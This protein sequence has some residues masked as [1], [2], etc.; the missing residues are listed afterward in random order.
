[1]GETYKTLQELGVPTFHP[2]KLHWRRSYLS[3]VES[4]EL[5]GKTFKTTKGKMFICKKIDKEHVYFYNIKMDRKYALFELP[6]IKQL[7]SEE[8]KEKLKELYP[9]SKLHVPSHGCQLHGDIDAT[10]TLSNGDEINIPWNY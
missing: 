5:I 3:E 6:T 4:G 7:T 10:L 2:E 1:M 8:Q 9:G